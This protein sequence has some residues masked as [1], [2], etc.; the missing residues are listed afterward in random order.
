MKQHIEFDESCKGCGGS[1]L[2]IGMAE[3][4]GAAIVCHNCNGTGCYHF[5]HEYDPF[6]GR[7]KAPRNPVKRV[8]EANPGIVIGEDK[9]FKLEDFGGMPYEDW[10]EEKPFERGMEN[11]KYTCP[12]WWYQSADYKRKPY[13]DECSCAGCFSSCK[14][15][16][17]KEKCWERFDE[18]GK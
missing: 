2:Y 12:A 18:E 9:G 14:H 3:K 8:Y 11:R 4:D 6:E 13:W 1:G 5:E 10:V 15:F 16:L 7:R 17:N